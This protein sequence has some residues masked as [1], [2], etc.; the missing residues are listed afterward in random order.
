MLQSVH[1]KMLSVLPVNVVL[2]IANVISRTA[3]TDY[4]QMPSV[5]GS[6]YLALTNGN[7]LTQVCAMM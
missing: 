6:T 5:P 2:M 3:G 1:N 7:T 4:K